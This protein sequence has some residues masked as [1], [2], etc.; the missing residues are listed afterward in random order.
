MTDN[1][2]WKKLEQRV[3]E[4]FGGR[5]NPLSGSNSQHGTS[6]D[7]IQ[8]AYPELYVE[9]KLRSGFA[10][11]TLFKAVVKEAAREHRIPV[12]V[13]HEKYHEGELVT[14][15]LD[16][17]I[18]LIHPPESLEDLEKILA[19]KAEH[20]EGWEQLEIEK[21][22]PIHRRVKFEAGGNKHEP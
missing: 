12:L 22:K 5:R 16:D 21:V 2:T 15:R 8:T 10:H 3:C 6:A 13:T 1:S 4:K 14:L 9:I 17:F 7:C 20:T 19:E 11:H 18:S